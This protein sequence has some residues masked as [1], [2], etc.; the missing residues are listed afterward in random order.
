MTGAAAAG[1]PVWAAAWADL[2]ALRL[3]AGL[4]WVRL[5]L[6]LAAVVGLNA[7]SL[8]WL[9]RGGG[10]GFFDRGADEAGICSG[11]FVL[12][13]ALLGATREAVRFPILLLD[14]FLPGY[15]WLEIL[16]L[17]E[18]SLV[19]VLRAEHLTVDL[20]PGAL[21]LGDVFTDMGCFPFHLRQTRPDVR[22]P[23]Q[24]RCGL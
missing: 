17:S 13:A 18:S 7:V 20:D 14:R 9:L 19:G 22:K 12:S 10:R 4:P 1:L 6:I 23:F 21:S 5:S 8:F 3:A 16:L 2:L 15:G 11:A 24:R